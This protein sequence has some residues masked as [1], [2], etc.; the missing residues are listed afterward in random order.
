M[1][2]KNRLVKLLI[3]LPVDLHRVFKEEAV[4]RR[5]TLKSIIME[6]FLEKVRR[7]SERP[8]HSEIKSEDKRGNTAGIAYRTTQIIIPIHLHAALKSQAAL[9]MTTIKNYLITSLIEKMKNDS[10]YRDNGNTSG[11]T[12]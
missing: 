3:E 12:L 10:A 4:F 8:P 11:G 9:R 7:D 2:S 6:A 5:T 1:K